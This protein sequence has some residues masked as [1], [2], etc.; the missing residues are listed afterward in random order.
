MESNLLY[1]KDDKDTPLVHDV[2]DYRIYAEE[3]RTSLLVKG[4]G[5]C[6]KWKNEI[7]YPVVSVYKSSDTTN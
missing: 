1:A 5:A 6:S 3:Y 7:Y 4:G 2:N